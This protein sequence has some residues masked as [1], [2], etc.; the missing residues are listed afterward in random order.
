MEQSGRA[1]L[2]HALQRR[3]AGSG[4]ARGRSRQ[5][6]T[7]GLR[8]P[9][10]QRRGWLTCDRRHPHQPRPSSRQI[11]PTA[12]LTRPCPRPSCKHATPAPPAASWGSAEWHCMHICSPRSPQLCGARLLCWVLGALHSCPDAT[13]T[14]RSRS[15]AISP[16]FK[17]TPSRPRASA[18][19]ARHPPPADD[20]QEAVW[21]EE[22]QNG[23][24][25]KVQVGTGGDVQDNLEHLER[26][27]WDMPPRHAAGRRTTGTI[28]AWDPGTCSRSHRELF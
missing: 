17:W 8:R 25:F 14:P 28:A 12:A 7:G 5:G 2:G 6:S 26:R 3:A 4:R 24:H 22:V 15:A 19:R 10:A 13:K 9:S 23:R 16:G 27:R 11:S 1:R 21:K 20:L 18:R